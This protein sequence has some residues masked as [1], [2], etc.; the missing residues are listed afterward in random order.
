[1]R[2]KRDWSKIIGGIK[3]TAAALAAL[4]SLAAAILK[5]FGKGKK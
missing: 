2:K 5:F 4:G 3:D 1:M